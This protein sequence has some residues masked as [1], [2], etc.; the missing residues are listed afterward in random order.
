MKLLDYVFTVVLLLIGLSCNDSHKQPE[1]SKNSLKQLFTF[2]GNISG[3]LPLRMRLEIGNDEVHGR[4][5]YE[6]I[7]EELRLE[8]HQSNNQLEIKLEIKEYNT[9]NEHTGTFKGQVKGEV[10]SGQWQ[11]ANGSK[12]LPFQLFVIPESD[13]FKDGLHPARKPITAQALP[14]PKVEKVR[15]LWRQNGLDGISHIHFNEAY[16]SSLSAPRKAI[17][18]YMSSMVG[19][20]CEQDNRHLTCM[21]TRKLGLGYQCENRHLGI[22]KEWF[23]RNKEVIENLNCYSV[24]GG[25]TYQSALVSVDIWENGN[26]LTLVDTIS[27]VAL[28][29]RIGKDIATKR[30]FKIAPDHVQLLSEDVIYKNEYKLGTY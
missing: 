21:L 20:D 19:T 30:T 22:I 23:K 2:H 29:D 12:T 27:Y 13:Y 6:S 4:Y 28:R 3:A 26:N 7:K 9:A 5:Y 16:F 14:E 17:L 25:A 24:P 15:V 8:G 11:S 18:A 10:F 1:A